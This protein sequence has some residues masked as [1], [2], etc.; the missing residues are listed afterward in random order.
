MH[1]ASLFGGNLDL[2]AESPLG[3]GLL[4]VHNDVRPVAGAEFAQQA[5]LPST[6]SLPPGS[7]DVRRVTVD[8]SAAD[9]VRLSIVNHGPVIP[10]DVQGRIFDPFQ[11]GPRP[12]GTRFDE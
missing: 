2:A 1:K 6:D 11:V 3:A 9:R 8:G 4:V 5:S 10:P 12:P 7:S